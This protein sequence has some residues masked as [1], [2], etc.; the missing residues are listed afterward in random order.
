MLYLWILQCM[1]CIATHSYEQMIA[2]TVISFFSFSCIRSTV[3]GQGLVA[4][5]LLNETRLQWNF[6]TIADT[7]DL[8][9]Y[10]YVGRYALSSFRY[11]P[12]R[13][14]KNESLYNWKML[15]RE[16]KKCWSPNRTHI[17]GVYWWWNIVYIL[18]LKN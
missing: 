15:V 1:L 10:A 12:K 14:L 4:N 9:C 5:M 8:Q 16:E 11:R 7:L 18:K 2:K 13:S 3:S 17:I 6:C